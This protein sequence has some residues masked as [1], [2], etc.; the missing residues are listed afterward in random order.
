[1]REPYN[2]L[3]HRWRAGPRDLVWL[4]HELAQANRVSLAA[5]RLLLR[6]VETVA[7]IQRQNRRIVKSTLGA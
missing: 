5:D 3:K 1:V 7:G 2:H 6:V 4:L